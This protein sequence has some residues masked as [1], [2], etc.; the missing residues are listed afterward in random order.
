MK[1]DIVPFEFSTDIAVAENVK[2]L[3]LTKVN[4]QK[5]LKQIEKFEEIY[6]DEIQE[7]SKNMHITRDGTVLFISDMEDEH[8]LNAIKLYLRNGYNFRTTQVKRYMTEIKKRNLVNKII[9]YK[10]KDIDISE[11]YED[12]ED[13]EDYND[14][15]D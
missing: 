8:L 10:I 6:E 13:Y 5:S 11:E 12:Y 2:N 3:L 1:Q 9:D 15:I 4:L 7:Q 14:L